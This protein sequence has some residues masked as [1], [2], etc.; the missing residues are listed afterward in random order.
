LNG[1]EEPLMKISCCDATIPRA[2]ISKGN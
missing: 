2:A 1:E